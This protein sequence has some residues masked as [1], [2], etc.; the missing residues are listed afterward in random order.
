MTARRKCDCECGRDAVVQFRKFNLCELCAEEI[1]GSN[2]PFPRPRVQDL[3]YVPDC[4][5]CGERSGA[6]MYNQ[7]R[8]CADCFEL[9]Q[10]LEFPG[11]EEL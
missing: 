6:I 7:R 2:G 5:D 9:L 11:D 8:Y 4:D 10:Q 1:L 3:V